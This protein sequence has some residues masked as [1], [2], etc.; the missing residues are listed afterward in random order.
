MKTAIVA[1]LLTFTFG[2]SGCAARERVRPA[3]TPGYLEMLHE[4]NVEQGTEL[5]SGQAEGD[6]IDGR[7]KLVT[8]NDHRTLNQKTGQVTDQNS[9]DVFTNSNEVIGYNFNGSRAHILQEFEDRHHP[10]S[11][12]IQELTQSHGWFPARSWLWFLS[13]DQRSLLKAR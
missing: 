6:L 9:Y 7:F 5:I 12:Q 4:Q 8:V 10:G 1:L 13:M 11:T 2:L 3:P